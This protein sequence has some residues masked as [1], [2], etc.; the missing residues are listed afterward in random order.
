MTTELTYNEFMN[1]LVGRVKGNTT[2]SDVKNI[3]TGMLKRNKIDMLSKINENE[4]DKICNMLHHAH[5]LSVK[6]NIALG[7]KEKK[8]ILCSPHRYVLQNLCLRLSIDGYT[9]EKFTAIFTNLLNRDISHKEE[10]LKKLQQQNNNLN[11][12]VDKNE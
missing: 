2:V 11:N 7:N 6:M 4:T 1:E 5:G 8:L 9:W 12:M 3:L 10:E